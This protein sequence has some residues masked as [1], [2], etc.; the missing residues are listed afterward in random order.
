MYLQNNLLKVIYP[1]RSTKCKVKRLNL[2]N[3]KLTLFD[4]EGSR[5]HE[6]LGDLGDFGEVSPLV[7]CKELEKI[8]LFNNSISSVFF[9]WRYDMRHLISVN[10]SHN[11]FEVLDFVQ[12]AFGTSPEID[13]RNNKISVINL[14]AAED[15]AILNKNGKTQ[16]WLLDGNPLSCNCS[17]Y[18]FLRYIGNNVAPEVCKLV[19]ETFRFFSS[20][21]DEYIKRNIFVLGFSFEAQ[22]S[23]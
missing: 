9:D 2:A 15:W 10:L 17:N 19:T 11:A 12:A 22:S 21:F 16:R 5:R 1:A 7:N 14:A 20:I 6:P 13:L 8:D 3:N 4:E 18:D 23:L